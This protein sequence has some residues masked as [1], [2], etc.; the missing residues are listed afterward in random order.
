MAKAK[1]NRTRY[2]TGK[3]NLRNEIS[4]SNNVHT[5]TE[6]NNFSQV[7][8]KKVQYRKTDIN[9]DNTNTSLVQDDDTESD[10]QHHSLNN[11]I[12]DNQSVVGNRNITTNEDNSMKFDIYNDTNDNDTGMDSN[13][14]DDEFDA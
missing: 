4:T 7:Q 11:E 8:E 5:D 1:N 9:N 14:E 12:I 10:I 3:S 2:N 6:M 13:T